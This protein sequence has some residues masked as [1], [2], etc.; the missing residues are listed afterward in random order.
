MHGIRETPE[1]TT[2][3][4]VVETDPSGVYEFTAMDPP[5]VDDVI[6]ADDAQRRPRTVRVRVTHLEPGVPFRIHA[7]PLRHEELRPPIDPLED[8]GA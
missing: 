8:A 4:V 7:V 6:D 1:P 5:A 2:H 3:P